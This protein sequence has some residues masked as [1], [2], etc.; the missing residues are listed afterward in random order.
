MFL[1]TY[2]L[3]SALRWI[4]TTS[5]GLEGHHAIPLRDKCK[6][7]YNMPSEIR[8]RKNRFLKPARIPF[9]SWAQSTP[10]GTRTHKTNRSSGLKPDAFTNFT[11]GAYEIINRI[12]Q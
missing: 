4:R 10:S 8:T 11:I 5:C 7:S 1:L 2:F 9:P 6:I 12:K 3:L